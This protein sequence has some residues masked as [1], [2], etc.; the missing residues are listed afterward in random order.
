MLLPSARRPARCRVASPR[1][2]SCVAGSVFQGP[3]RKRLGRPL[4]YHWVSG[5]SLHPLCGKAAFFRKNR[6]AGPLR[7]TK[8][9]CFG[10]VFVEP[11]TTT[12]TH[13]W[14]TQGVMNMNT[15]FGLPEAR[16][17]VFQKKKKRFLSL[18][19]FQGK[20]KRKTIFNKCPPEVSARVKI[21]ARGGP[22]N[23]LLLICWT[24]Q[25][26]PHDSSTTYPGLTP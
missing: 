23:L 25:N 9:R 11:K 19:I 2:W 15:R 24:S 7:K 8:M 4:A 3:R 13:I 10:C 17:F 6:G 26:S 21:A 14:H 22:G 20:Q 12:R 1:C 5:N 18:G 16:I